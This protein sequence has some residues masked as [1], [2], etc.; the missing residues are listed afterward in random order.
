MSHPT[1]R[2]DRFIRGMLK[3]NRR[4]ESVCRGELPGGYTVQEKEEFIKKSKCLRR[5]T[6][7]LCSCDMCRN[8][9]RS[10]WGDKLTVQE[11]KFLESLD[12]EGL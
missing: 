10:V 2:R 5:S 8:P 11:K 3:G 1:D 9:R 12:N 4:A 6:T 7:K